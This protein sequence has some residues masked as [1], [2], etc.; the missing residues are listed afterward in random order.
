MVNIFLKKIWCLNRLKFARIMM[1][2]MKK[3]VDNLE[4]VTGQG[5]F[6]ILYWIVDRGSLALSIDVF[7]TFIEDHFRSNREG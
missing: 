3:Q 5:H 2:K 1:R 7:L 4:E 6:E